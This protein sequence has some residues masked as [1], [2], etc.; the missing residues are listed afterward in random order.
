MHSYELSKKLLVCLAIHRYSLLFLSWSLKKTPTALLIMTLGNKSSV[1]LQF[2]LYFA[3]E[4]FNLLTD[5]GLYIDSSSILSECD[6]VIDIKNSSELNGVGNSVKCS[7]GGNF[8]SSALK[9][10]K[11]DLIILQ[12]TLA[13]FF[14]C[15]AVLFIS[16]VVIY[17]K[18]FKAARSRSFEYDCENSEFLKSFYK[19]HG[20][21]L[22]FGTILHDIPVG[23]IVVELCVLVWQQPNCWECV[24]IFSSTS[25]SEVSL[26]KTNL[27]LGIKLGSLAPITFYKGI[28]E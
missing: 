14:I 19:I 22:G 28:Y 4:I 13:G 3:T 11:T 1:C 9:S 5:V 20:F 16:Q 27:W 6:D 15:G 21:I 7:D 10:A 26:S 24:K 18:Y 12:L 2:F 17:C 8:T 23:L 25:F